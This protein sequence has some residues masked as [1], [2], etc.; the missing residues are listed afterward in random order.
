MSTTL[1]INLPNEWWY[2]DA[3]TPLTAFL[4]FG[5]LN[6]TSYPYEPTTFSGF[7]PSYI[8]SDIHTYCSFSN[9]E[10]T[11]DYLTI[12]F[13]I[14][15]SVN[16]NEVSPNYDENTMYYY[17]F[18]WCQNFSMKISAKINGS[19]TTNL[20]FNVTNISQ[21]CEVSYVNGN[22]SN[23]ECK[24][25]LS[26]TDQVNNTSPSNTEFTPS[27]YK[28]YLNSSDTILE[29]ELSFTYSL[30]TSPP[31]SF[32]IVLDINPNTTSVGTDNSA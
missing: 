30:T 19:S 6:V 31:P 17:D 1:T 25:T 10:Y 18:T 32:P 27:N 2:S 9:P 28:V 15:N 12:T 7:S 21:T 22:G 29:Y 20:I 4:N 24:S 3:N 14:N 5:Y 13:T 23:L 16:T 26:S 11:V 8:T